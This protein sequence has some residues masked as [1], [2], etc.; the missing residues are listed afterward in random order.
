MRQIFL[1]AGWS[2]ATTFAKYYENY[3]DTETF[4]KV[5]LDSTE[6]NETLHAT[7]KIL[8]YVNFY[9]VLLNTPKVGYFTNILS[10]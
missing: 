10:N 1:S 8:P 7:N 3:V 9:E 6:N 2:N 4:V 5:V